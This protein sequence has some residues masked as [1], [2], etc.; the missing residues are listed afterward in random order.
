MKTLTFEYE[1]VIKA[2]QLLNRL[3][4]L[5]SSNQGLSG[6]EKSRIIAE[7]ANFMDSGFPGETFEKGDKTDGAVEQQEVGKD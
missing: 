1:S 5:D 6:I 7:L 2:S 4:F 3:A